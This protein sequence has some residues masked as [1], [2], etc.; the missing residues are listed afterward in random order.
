MN[1]PDDR[2]ATITDALQ[3]LAADAALQARAAA[4]FRE[5]AEALRQGD[6]VQRI[7]EQLRAEKKISAVVAGLLEEIDDALGNL[8]DLED[9]DPWT[10]HSIATL[11]EWSEIR[12]LA[13]RTL[14]ALDVTPRAPDWVP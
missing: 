8:V 2:L 7:D 4:A 3:L 5:I 14:M 11:P 1:A 9:P 6:D 10:P 12:A 13:R